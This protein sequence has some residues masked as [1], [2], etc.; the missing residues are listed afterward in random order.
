[1][2]L[3]H[4]VLNTRHEHVLNHH[5][6]GNRREQKVRGSG[7]QNAPHRSQR[8]LTSVCTPVLTP[9]RRKP[10][11][12]LEFFLN[13]RKR[14]LIR[15]LSCEKSLRVRRSSERTAQVTVRPRNEP[16]R[17][18]SSCSQ[19]GLTYIIDKYTTAVSF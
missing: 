18:S 15:N 17:Q 2:F 7:H 4:V 16:G 1:M 19:K 5:P 3:Q 14:F 9:R 6:G 12:I 10:D 11:A 8:M 13:S